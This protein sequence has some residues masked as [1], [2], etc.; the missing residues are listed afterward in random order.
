MAQEQEAAFD[1]ATLSVGE[2]FEGK[3]RIDGIIGQGATSIVYRAFQLSVERE[4]ALKILKTERL[5]N[6]NAIR[7]FKQEALALSKL[8]SPY[9][10]KVYSYGVCASGMPFVVTELLSGKNLSVLISPGRAL[11]PR[12]FCSIFEQLALGLSAAHA[13]QIIH[14]DIKPGNILLTPLNGSFDQHTSIESL[15]FRAKLLDFGLAKSLEEGTENQS[16]TASGVFVGSPAYMSPE[17]CRSQKLDQRSDIYSLGVVMYEALAGCCPFPA[18]SYLDVMYKHSEL[19]APTL[20]EMAPSQVVSPEIEA[21]VMRCLEKEPSKRFQTAAQL[22]QAIQAVEQNLSTES[23]GSKS[24]DRAK[25]KLP[26][27]GIFLA[28]IVLIAGIAYMGNY[29]GIKNSSLPAAKDSQSLSSSSDSHAL[30]RTGSSP[31]FMAK[32]HR[33]VAPRLITLLREKGSRENDDLSAYVHDLTVAVERDRNKV[34]KDELA[35][36]Y[37]VL[38][39]CAEGKPD[40]ETSKAYLQKELKILGAKYGTENNNYKNAQ[41]R[42]AETLIKVGD[43]QQAEP[44]ALDAYNYF[45]N[46]KTI[47]SWAD[48]ANAIRRLDQA[49]RLSGKFAEGFQLRQLAIKCDAAN[50][51]KDIYFVFDLLA[52]ASYCDELGL[53][54]DALKY[55]SLA[56]QKIRASRNIVMPMKIG[57]MIWA[58]RVYAH[59]K[60]TQD[61]RRTLND[62]EILFS[63]QRKVIAGA[64]AINTRLSCQRAQLCVLEGEPG[65][66]NKYAAEA[67]SNLVK[68]ALTEELDSLQDLA[69]V[70]DAIGKPEDALNMYSMAIGEIERTKYGNGGPM[71]IHKKMALICLKMGARQRALQYFRK[72]LDE[73]P[74]GYKGKDLDEI[75]EKYDSLR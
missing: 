26:L 63:K 29:S 22:A 43:S 42:L 2:L 5:A 69:E 6:E 55:C 15:E 73:Q 74:Y 65:V 70:Y 71:R 68:L 41:G 45:W 61:L 25:Q 48:R 10:L 46:K 20:A 72:A 67:A 52:A 12:Q 37:E 32:A 33:K 18:E 49:Y 57:Q 53:R 13:G 1:G 54:K 58:C 56:L 44:L 47:C 38:S 11:T 60:D 59:L 35:E 14:R 23:N 8:D 40:F 7:R 9:I 75:K 4:V 50:D 31:A 21:L 28:A 3:F 36:A 62:A 64:A 39:G 30:T 34:S 19:A 17:Q 27:R 24:L 16:K 51:E 66:A